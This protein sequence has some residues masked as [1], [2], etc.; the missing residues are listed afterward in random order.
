MYP[1]RV[2]MTVSLKNPDLTLKLPVKFTG[3]L[4]D[5]QLDV[6]LTFPLGKN[7]AKPNFE[8]IPSFCKPDS[9]SLVIWEGNNQIY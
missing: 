7:E 4:S 9:E 1:P 8:H 6:E 2:K 5:S 3:C